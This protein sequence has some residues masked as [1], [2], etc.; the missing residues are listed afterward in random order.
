MVSIVGSQLIQTVIQFA[1]DETITGVENGD[2][3]GWSISIN[4]TRPN[5]LF[6]KPI[7][8]DSDTNMT[9]ITDQHIYQFHLSMHPKETA[10]DSNVTYSIRFK[11]PETIKKELAAAWEAKDR[12]KKSL[13][14]DY[15]V[16]PLSWN[17]SYSYSKRCA[18]DLVPIR[19]FDDGRFT[20]FQFSPNTEIPAIFVVDGAGN[21]A[22]ANW[23]MEGQYVVIE[24]IAR[25]FSLRN[26]N[27]SSCIFNDQ[28][29]S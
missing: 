18:R 7:I 3:V 1:D 9:V 24:R 21:E 15:P 2:A 11:Y 29:H 14:T 28:Y 8:D 13:V 22:L 4:K 19:A 17:W 6:I 23:R 26:G 25:Q 12:L 5:L 16:N 20:Y 27:I 10:N